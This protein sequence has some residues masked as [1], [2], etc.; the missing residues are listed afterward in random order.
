MSEFMGLIRGQYIAKPEGFLPGGASL[1][2]CMLPHG[3]A[4]EVHEAASKAVL[5]PE[6]LADT[7]AFMF[8][9]RYPLQPTDWALNS[10]QRQAGYAESWSALP[11]HFTHKP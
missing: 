1:H 5:E 10:P 3:P 4:I 11:K 8:E 7:L 9:S 6:F 2:N